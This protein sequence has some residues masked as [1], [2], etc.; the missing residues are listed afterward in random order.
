VICIVNY[1]V[2]NIRSVEKALIRSGAQVCVSADMTDLE[3]ADGLVLPGVGAFAAA[4]ESLYSSHGLAEVILDR[5]KAGVPLLGVC[6]GFQLLFDESEEDGLHRGLGLIPGRVVKLP[7]GLKVPHIGWDKVF[8][9]KNAP[10]FSNVNDATY[11]Y[12]VHSYHAVDVPDNYVIGTA[13]YGVVKIAAAV[14]KGH[15]FGTQFHP[16]KSSDAGIRVYRN[17]VELCKSRND[18]A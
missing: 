10:L 9:S 15:I 16:E 6:L 3:H 1:G 5:V 11:F 14:A 17:F 18:C 12:F 7:K 13:D 8:I 2:G 4:H